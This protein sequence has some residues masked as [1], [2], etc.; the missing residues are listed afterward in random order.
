MNNRSVYVFFHNEQVLEPVLM[1]ILQET[2]QRG[3][4]IFSFEF[5][6]FWLNNPIFQIF[7]P[8]LSLF[9]GKQY[10]PTDKD[11]FGVFLDSTPDRWG[12]QLIDRRETIL[13]RKEG[14]PVIPRT[15]LDYL[16]GVFDESRM[17][18]LRF[19]QSLDGDFIDNDK[20]L[21]TPPWESLRKL[22]AASLKL[23][24][25][26]NSI[27]DRWLKMLL[28]PGSSLG[29]ARPKANVVDEHGHLWIAK[30]PSKK[31][32]K[33]V[34]AWETVCM[35][36]AKKCGVETSDFK[37]IKLGSKYHTFLTKRF[38]RTENNVRKHFTSAMTHL[39]YNDG[40]N[41]E[42]GASYLELVEWISEHCVNVQGNLEQLFKRIIFNIA[43][44]NCDDHLRN[45]GFLLT[46]KGWT[47]SPAYDLTPDEYGTELSLNIN[48]SEANLDY[49]LAREVAPYFGIAP[50]DANRIIKKTN[51][52][53]SKWQKVATDIGISRSE[54]EFIAT[55]FRTKDGV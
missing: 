39:D 20:E 4:S 40:A 35:T 33:D 8:N 41:G 53:V 54:Q 2:L 9:R 16:L 18:A 21:A 50:S 36:L 25:D 51:D 11:N 38:D 23:E 28:R 24:Q 19:K 1:G 48:E 13:A 6:K 31:D 5:D 45:H 46:P 10:A 14:R 15:E 27:D 37:C 30:F 49:N 3:K 43:I 32:R 55:A 22:E 26:E 52:V 44:S 7:D 42:T 12:R 47:L 29:G 17:G 34:G